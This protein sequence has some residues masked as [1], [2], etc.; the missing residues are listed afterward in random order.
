MAVFV[1]LLVDGGGSCLTWLPTCYFLLL[2]ITFIWGFS[3]A[4]LLLVGF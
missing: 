2:T 1:L 4:L 3:T